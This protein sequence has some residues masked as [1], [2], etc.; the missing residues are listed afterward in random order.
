MIR[1]KYHRGRIQ[2]SWDR[3]A[4]NLNEGASLGNVNTFTTI[5]DL[6]ETDEVTFTVPYVQNRQFLE[7]STRTY[8]SPLPWTVASTPPNHYNSSTNGIINVRVLNRLTAPEASSDVTLLV[9]VSAGDDIEFAAPRNPGLLTTN[10]MHTLSSLSSS[11]AQSSIVYD[12]A[13][14]ETSH[15]VT[16]ADPAVYLECFGEKVTSLRELLHRSS[17]S[18]SWVFSGNS[19]GTTRIAIPLKHMPPSPGVWNNGTDLPLISGVP[20][21]GFICP[22]HPIPWIADCFIGSKGSVNVTG[23]VKTG[24]GA[25]NGGWVDVLSIDRTADGVNLSSTDRRQ[26]ATTVLASDSLNTNTYFQN[27]IPAGVTGKALSNTRTNASVAANLPFYSNSAFHVVDLYTTYNNQDAFSG[28]NN[29]WFSLIV[30]TPTE[31]TN[32]NYQS[33]VDVYYGTGP[34]YDL[35]FFIN[36]PVIY[37]RTYT[38]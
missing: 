10:A 18:K 7:T 8:V 12:D 20:Q 16:K 1:S 3:S 23:N 4:N 30:Q 5:M 36:T 15:Q 26:R 9:Y 24:A 22:Q 38:L 34:D 14:E 31:T 27:T 32:K 28:A 37:Y 19:D 11:I 25:S 33:S 29:D 35:V 21:F 6:D 13:T 17:L 2:I